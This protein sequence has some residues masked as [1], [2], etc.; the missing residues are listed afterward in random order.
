M[1]IDM[2]TSGFEEVEHTADVA[3]KVWGRDRA[4][5]FINAARG[6][7]WLLAELEEGEPTV[8]VAVELEALDAETLMVSW[9][10][11]LLFLAEEEEVIFTDFELEEITPTH[12]AGK[13]Y[14]RPVV[15]HRAHIKA[16]TFSEMDIRR[17]P[18]GWETK[19]VFDV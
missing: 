17:T 4:E 12:V 14:G 16:V 7:A 10:G 1:D 11:E 15:E 3:L 19:I 9:L 6:M 18:R 2:Q 8:E 13:V 5:L